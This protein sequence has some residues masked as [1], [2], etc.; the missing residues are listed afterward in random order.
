MN[1]LINNLVGTY[2]KDKVSEKLSEV[3]EQY[4]K[5]WYDHSKAFDEKK[6]YEWMA[7]R[8]IDYKNILEVGCGTGFSTL[9]LLNQGH[10]VIA[11]DENPS[12]LK[13][14]EKL[15]KK[16]GYNVKLILRGKVIAIDSQKYEIKYEDL[17]FNQLDCDVVLVESDFINDDKFIE[18][19]KNDLTEVVDGIVCWL[20][21]THNMRG[22]NNLFNTTI[23]KNSSDA[24]IF[25]QK[26][27][28]QICDEILSSGKGLNIIDR[29]VYQEYL[30]EMTKLEHIRLSRG[31]G[32]CIKKIKFVDY[33]EVGKDRGTKM[34]A[35]DES[36]GTINTDN[37]QKVLVST[38]SIKK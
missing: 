15:L 28:Y 32:F 3:R 19:I 22:N 12:C 38:L 9:N 36:G 8:V 11:V 37:Y 7:K 24:R 27:L 4:S 18:F 14:A 23:T 35:R 16:N 10:K 34:I 17:T 20:L 6:Y 33:E 13:K 5:E 2:K 26:R 31:T 1:S 29:A 21:G 30:V 25:V